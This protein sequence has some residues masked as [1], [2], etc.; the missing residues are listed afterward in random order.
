MNRDFFKLFIEIKKKKNISQR[1]V[2]VPDGFK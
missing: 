1:Q 2:Q